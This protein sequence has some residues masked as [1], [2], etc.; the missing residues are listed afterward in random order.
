MCERIQKR[1]SNEKSLEIDM[2]ELSKESLEAL[3]KII[4]FRES[5]ASSNTD[6]AN[7]IEKLLY[8]TNRYVIKDVLIEICP[9]YCM[10]ADVNEFLIDKT[11]WWS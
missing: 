5:L 7:N 11:I 4:S 6:K 1:T 9:N 8:E 10:V 2:K 3:R